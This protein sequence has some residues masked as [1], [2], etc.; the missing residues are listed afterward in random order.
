MATPSICPALGLDHRRGQ[1]CVF[2]HGLLD[3]DKGAQSREG[4]RRLGVVTVLAADDPIAQLH[5]AALIEALAALDWHEGSNL[6]ID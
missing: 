2:Q 1:F 6:H 3:A 5:T 4:M